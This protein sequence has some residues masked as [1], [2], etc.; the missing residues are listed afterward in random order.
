MHPLSCVCA[1]NT[2]VYLGHTVDENTTMT[3]AKEMIE[4][5]WAMSQRVSVHA[6]VCVRARVPVLRLKV[7]PMNL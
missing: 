3:D 4:L 1:L 2:V 6:C 7:G 5:T